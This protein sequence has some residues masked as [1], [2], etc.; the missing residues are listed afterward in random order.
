MFVTTLKGFVFLDGTNTETETEVKGIVNHILFKGGED[1]KPTMALKHVLATYR[2]NIPQPLNVS[3]QEAARFL[4]AS[5]VI[6]HLDLVKREDIGTGEGKGHP[7]WN[8]YIAPPTTNQAA[9]TLGARGHLPSGYI[10]SLL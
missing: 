10:V 6:R 3:V 2:N 1:S 5:A 7:A 8:V 9:L 4:Q